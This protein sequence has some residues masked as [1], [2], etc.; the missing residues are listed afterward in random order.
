MAIRILVVDDASFIRDMIKKH[1]RDGIPGAQ[2]YEA[3][4]GH[5]ALAAFKAQRVDLIL[6]DWEMPSMSGEELL[7]SLKEQ[8]ESAEVPFVMVTS[9]GDRS[10]V[11]KAI[12][13]GAADYL[14][15][16]FTPEELLRKVNKQLAQAGKLAGP[17]EPH[18]AS[19]GIAQHSVD[20][21]TAGRAGGAQTSPKAKPKPSSISKKLKG[22]AQLRFAN[23]VESETC[24]LRELSTEQLTGLI[25]RTESLPKVFDQV[26][27][28]LES[29]QEAETPARLNGYVH[30]VQAAEAKPD[31]QFLRL[32]ILFVDKD[33]AKT[34]ALS[35]FIERL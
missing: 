31:T 20:V 18:A 4:N 12:E 24:L 1:L 30:S 29:D 22:R 32:V 19:Q 28:D 15:K 9:R 2:V 17:A 26:V 13:A 25:K 21:L 6:S 5:R 10:H 3:T 16:P 27:I 35:R 7:R 33:K 8:P 11:V 14:V 23:Q 34:Q